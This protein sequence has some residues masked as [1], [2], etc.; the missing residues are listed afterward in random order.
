MRKSKKENPEINL[1][2]VL[3]VF[4]FLNFPSESVIFFDLG[5]CLFPEI[6]FFGLGKHAKVSADFDFPFVRSHRQTLFPP[7]LSSFFST[8]EFEKRV[9]KS[10]S[11]R[12]KG[13]SPKTALANK[14]LKRSSSKV[15]AQRVKKKDYSERVKGKKSLCAKC[16]TKRRKAELTIT[17][18]AKAA[19]DCETSRKKR[20]EEKERDCDRAKFGIKQSSRLGA[21][22]FHSASTSA[23]R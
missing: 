2:I 22:S 15:P 14:S 6:F 7:T 18:Q 10:E 16:K 19:S 13:F 12:T 11:L 5:C 4:F 17:G 8:K 3:W 9:V 21:R 20:E 23:A 1:A